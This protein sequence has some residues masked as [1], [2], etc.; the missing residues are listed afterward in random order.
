MALD[1]SGEIIVAVDRASAF[2]VISDP[3]RLAR[4]IPGCEELRELSTDRYTAVLTS[5]VAFMT[6]RFAVAIAVVKREPPAT[7]EATITGDAVGLSGRVVATASVHLADT[8][9]RRT[10]I[11]YATTVALTGKL[12]GLGQSVFR[13]TSV[14]M[15]REF[16]ENLRAEIERGRPEPSA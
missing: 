13:A 7:I 3:A 1:A 2:V 6:L 8:A 15:A 12:G 14:S 5:R 4:C 9:D 10:I 16:G 11:R